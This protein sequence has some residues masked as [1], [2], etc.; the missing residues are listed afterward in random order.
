[1]IKTNAMNKILF[2]FIVVIILA[3]GCKK[4]STVNNGVTYRGVV[5][6]SVCLHSVVQ[7]IGP[8]YLGENGWVGS[9]GSQPLNHVFSVQNYCQFGGHAIGDTFN[10]KIVPPQSQNCAYCME[11]IDAPT[12]AYSIEIVP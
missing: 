12:T 4:S 1:M 7:S 5:I 8:N 9:F 3:C 6:R 11:A 2:S 10:F